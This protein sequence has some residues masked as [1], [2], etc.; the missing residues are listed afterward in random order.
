MGISIAIL[1]GVFLTSTLSGLLGMAG[2]MI[3][4][5][6]LLALLSVPA[7]MILHGAVQATANGSRAWFLRRHIAWVV[8]PPYVLGAGAALALFIWLSITP[9]EGLI[10]IVIGL[11]PWLARALPRLRGLDVT[12]PQTAALCGLVVTAAQL[13]AGVSGPLL[14]VFYLNSK[15]DRFGVIASKALTQAL[16]HILKLVYWGGVI[17]VSDSLPPLLIAMAMLA[18]VLGTR[19]GTILLARW[20]QAGFQRWSAAVILGIA[21][22]CL[23]RGVTLLLLA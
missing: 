11:F 7:T 23:I 18:A 3:L 1:I 9:N 12:K 19:L 16:G 4:M 2:G 22:I 5:A 13:F 20:N 6:I 8:L 15:L 10:L 21:T 17:G 14:D